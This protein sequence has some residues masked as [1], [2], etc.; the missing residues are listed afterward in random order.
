MRILVGADVP[1]DPNSGAAGT[2]YQ[3]NRA[4]RE[5]GHEVDEIWADDIGRRIQHG[6]A[7]Y[8]LELPYR[9]R[10][11]VRQRCEKKRYDVFQLSQPHAYLAAKDHRN[12][13]R[14]GIFV[15]RSHGLELRVQDVLPYWEKCYG[16]NRKGLLRSLVSKGIQ[17]QIANQWRQVANYSDGIILPS[18][19]DR[20][21]LVKALKLDESK[22]R[23]IHHGVS[24]HFLSNAYHGNQLGRFHKLLYV[25]QYTFMKGP[26][27]LTEVVNDLLRKYPSAAFTWV[28]SK[29]HHEQV[30]AKIDSTVRPRFSL[31]DWMPQDQLDELYSEH[32]IFIFPSFFEGAG[33]AALEAM[34]CGMC[35]ISSDTGGMRDYIDSGDNGFLVEVGDFGGFVSTAIR[36]LA[37]STLC[38]AVGKRAALHAREYTW[39]RCARDAVGFYRALL[40]RR[41]QTLGNPD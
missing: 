3:T 36:L 38:L 24:G 6:N 15:N 20:Q 23:T 25:G 40:K 19:E 28:C 2:V 22:V 34:A 12:S 32:G 8:L 39:E 27:V 9:F 11:I 41:G 31:L 30:L 18:E 14:A 29:A 1:K 13:K 4:L 16:A 21:F 37:D 35:V 7:H 26:D 10:T 17:K 5:L 33:K